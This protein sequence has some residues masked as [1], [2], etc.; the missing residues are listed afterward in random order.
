[1][2]Q[3]N[4]RLARIS[5]RLQRHIC[6]QRGCRARHDSAYR[7]D[8]QT[9]H[10]QDATSSGIGEVNMIACIMSA[11]R[12]DALVNKGPLH[13]AHR[14]EQV[15]RGEALEH[16]QRRRERWRA[17]RRLVHDRDRR[18]PTRASNTEPMITKVWLELD[19][20]GMHIQI[21]VHI[22]ATEAPSAANPYGVF[23]LDYCGKVDGSAG[24]PC[25]ASSKAPTAA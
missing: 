6:R 4:S 24:C 2:H 13:R 19:E 25:A 10:V 9:S 17:G 12:P 11:M 7:T 18:L 5:L 14:Q 22:S 15:R 23:R 21:S 8:L 20:E 3:F 1:M 16:R